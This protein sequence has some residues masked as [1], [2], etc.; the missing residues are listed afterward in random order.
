MYDL[1]AS[2]SMS[3]C[4]PVYCAGA[5][6][7]ELIPALPSM[8]AVREACEE[9]ERKSLF[10]ED[11]MFNEFAPVAVSEPPSPEKK[12]EDEEPQVD[13]AAKKKKKK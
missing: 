5:E 2:M 11:M 1:F 3:V 4:L 7:F 6:I 12:E 9:R 10:E 13:A 8:V